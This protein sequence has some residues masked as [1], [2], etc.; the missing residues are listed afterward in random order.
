MMCSKITNLN[1]YTV[2]GGNVVIDIVRSYDYFY[3][4]PCLPD[5]LVLDDGTYY[6][7]SDSGAPCDDCEERTVN[8]FE[9]GADGAY[10]PACNN[11]R[12]EPDPEYTV[13]DDR[14]GCLSFT[15]KLSV[16]E[17]MSRSRYE[18]YTTKIHSLCRCCKVIPT[19]W[20][21]CCS[22]CGDGAISL[23]ETYWLVC[24]ASPHRDIVPMILGLMWL[25]V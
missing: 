24:R 4:S 6:L 1:Q 18:S 2:C 12:I 13:D 3:G 7:L 16:T 23:V 22:Y 14:P 9:W 19:Y 25:Y 20:D 8:A 11:M 5:N 10:C 15:M 21:R 17:F